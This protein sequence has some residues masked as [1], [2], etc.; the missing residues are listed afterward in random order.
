MISCAKIFK[1][2]FAIKLNRIKL[3]KIL[4][5]ASVHALRKEHSSKLKLFQLILTS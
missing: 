3:M 5:G 1:L 2:D 4:V